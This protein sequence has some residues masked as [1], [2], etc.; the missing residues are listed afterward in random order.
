[1][2]AV[3]ARGPRDF[4]LVPLRPPDGDAPGATVRVLAAGVCAAD[5]MLW[6]GDG[7]W[8]VRYPLVP[9]HEIVGRIEAVDAASADGWQVDVGDLVGVEVMVPCGQC[10]Y[11]TAD[12]ENLCRNGAHLGS[13]LP[14]GFADLVHLPPAARVHVI[15][16]TVPLKAA[17]VLEPLANAVHAVRRAEVPAGA[18]VAVVGIGAV[19][20]LVVQVLRAVVP[21]A[22]VTAVVNHPERAGQ[23]RL[24]GAHHVVTTT[25]GDPVGE[26]RSVASGDG[27]ARVIE[28]SGNPA[29]A[30]LALDAVAHGGRICLYGVYRQPAL[31]DLNLVAEFKELDLVGG[32]LAPAGAF[33]QAVDLLAAAR[34]RA[35]SVVTEVLPLDR[36]AA[37]LEPPRPGAVRLKTVLTP[38]PWTEAA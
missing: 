19:G 35:E 1:V 32:H 12:R 16:P 4:T 27:P 7:P 36:F 24:L 13:D 31:V 14:G 22:T 2:H 34:V 25:G 23:A 21:T 3:L 33:R 8:Q 9:G 10:R 38:T 11:C 30:Q 29:A 5:R 15:P 37:A 6:R 28:A 26:L 20:A 17:A 18:H